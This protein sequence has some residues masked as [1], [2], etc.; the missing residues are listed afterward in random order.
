VPNVSASFPPASSFFGLRFDHEVEV[1]RSSKNLGFL[2]TTQHY[3]PEGSI[4]Q[5][6]SSSIIRNYK[7]VTILFNPKTKHRGFSPQVNDADRATAACRRS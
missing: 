4:L 5:V 6:P 1:F 2:Q 7:N 3:N